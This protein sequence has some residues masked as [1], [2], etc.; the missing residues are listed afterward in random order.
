M[1]RAAYFRL[2]GPIFTIWS[3]RGNCDSLE[4][5]AGLL[6]LRL[7]LNALSAG[8]NMRRRNFSK[9]T[10]A[11]RFKLCEGRCESCGVALKPG[12]WHGDHN[13]PDGLTGEPTLENCRCLC[14]ACHA[15]KT[16]QDVAVIAKAV[17]VEA[18]HLG[19]PVEKQKIVS[20]GFPKSEKRKR[21]ELPALPRRAMFK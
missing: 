12:T 19:V 1:M 6:F 21:I 5:D 17:R 10:L 7:K 16:K 4:L 11:E 18:K 9:K 2:A 14:V 13:N 8:H 20:K 15:A 3:A